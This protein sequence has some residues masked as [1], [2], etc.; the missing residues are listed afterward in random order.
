MTN[1]I[2]TEVKPCTHIV[3][4]VQIE[5]EENAQSHPRFPR[6]VR[7]LLSIDVMIVFSL[8]GCSA[9][10]QEEEVG[11][12][13][14]RSFTEVAVDFMEHKGASAQYDI[15]VVDEDNIRWESTLAFLRSQGADMSRYDVLKGRDFQAVYFGHSNRNVAGGEAFVL[16]DRKSKE[17]IFWVGFM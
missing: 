17:V 3:G 15:V 8:V 1:M 12:Y 10:P 5:P 4:R 2:M 7:W 6:L 9:V 14:T 13:E 16:L 11:M